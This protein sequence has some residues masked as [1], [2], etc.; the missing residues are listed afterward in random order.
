MNTKPSPS[1]P[2]ASTTHRSLLRTAPLS[3]VGLVASCTF[4]VDSTQDLPDA[5]PGDYAC[6]AGRGLCTLRAAIMEAN[7]APTIDTILVPAGV[8]DLDLPTNSG[9]GRLVISNSVTVQG[10]GKDTTIINQTVN[11]SVFQIT[12]G[13][14]AV[15]NVTVQGGDSQAGGGFNIGN[16]IVD[17][18]D[19]VIRENFGFTGG[20]GI[21]VNAGGDVR[22][23]RVSIRDNEATGAFGGGIWNQG[24]LWV[25]ESEI[26]DNH[27]NRAGG[28]RNSGNLNLRNVT[29]SGNYVHSPDAGVGGISQNGFAVLNNVTVTEN[30]GA[31]NSPGSF[32][33]GGIQTTAGET[34][35]MKNS[36]V[37][38]NDGGI[39]PDD[40]VGSLTADSKYNLIGNTQ[41]CTIPAFVFTYI[42]DQPANLGALALNGGP[43]RNHLPNTASPARDSGYQFPPPA[44]DACE[45]HDQRGVPRPQG[46]GQCDMG[47][48]EYT[49]ANQFVTGFVLVDAGTD[50]DIGPLLHGDTLDLSALPPDLSVRAQIA[51]VPGS[52]IFD[53]D[54]TPMFQI[55]NLSPYALGGDAGGDYTPVA[56]SAGEHSIRATPY[57]Q[58]NGTGAAGGSWSIAFSVVD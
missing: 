19:A 38:G 10:A 49:T 31:G 43:T 56:L 46:V 50:T 28:I 42:L 5:N 33:G 51:T 44:V 45:S 47:A 41:D 22:V 52:V 24:V 57:S 36:V 21:L 29:V 27:S 15:N 32:R 37:A 16:A 7:F 34:T 12:N 48:V 20:G 17:I 11:D 2:G 6:D 58:N 53:F 23:R 3:L 30:T 1:Y 26:T 40:C 8:Y 14:V 39:G 35:V 54:D 4:Q 18:T 13:E 9:G 55:E 25:Y